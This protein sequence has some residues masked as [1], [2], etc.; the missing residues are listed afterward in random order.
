MA[1][2]EDEHEFVH[3][4]RTES[5]WETCSRCN[6]DMHRCGGCGEWLYHGTN[7]CGPCRKLHEEE[8]AERDHSNPGPA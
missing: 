7:I 8:E 1:A 3:G 2:P 6:Y 4:P 5:E